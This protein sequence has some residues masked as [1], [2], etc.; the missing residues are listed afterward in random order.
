MGRNR[1]SN[2]A[3]TH[4]ASGE[5]AGVVGAALCQPFDTAK[6]LMQLDTKKYK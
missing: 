1:R 6:T 4:F 2:G 3:W 5:V